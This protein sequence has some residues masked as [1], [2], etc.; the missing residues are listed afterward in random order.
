[1]AFNR[2]VTIGPGR[3]IELRMSR[4]IGAQCIRARGETGMV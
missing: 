4:V 1:M 3:D 2:Y